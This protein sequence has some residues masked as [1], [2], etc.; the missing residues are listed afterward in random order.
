MAALESSPLGFDPRVLTDQS[1]WRVADALYTGLMKKAPRGEFLPDLAESC[2]SEDARVWSCRLRSG[3]LF[4][5]GRPMTSSDVA[6]TYE[7]VL[8]EG[9]RSSKKQALRVIERI[10]TPSPLMVV[11]HLRSPYSSFPNQLLLGIIP[12][13]TS[14][15]AARARP[16]G[17]GPFLFEF[18]RPDDRVSLRRFDGFYGEKARMARVVMRVIPDTTT[19]ALE[20]LRGSVHL[21]INSLSPDM[22]PRMEAASGVTVSR[23]PGSNHGYIAFNFKDPVLSKKEV[24]QALALALDR[25]ALASGLWRDTVEVTETLLPKDHWATD[26]DLP[27]LERDLERAGRLLDQAGFPERAEGRPRLT[28]TFKTS[29]DEMTVLQATAIAAQWREA[30]V[31][32]VI[33]SHDFSIFYEDVIHG[34]FR[35]FSMRWQGITDPDHYHDVFHTRSFPPGGW[36]RGFFS[37]PLVDS[38]IEKAR[39]TR[40]RQERQRLYFALQRRLLDELPYIPLYR[41]L[42]VAVHDSRLTGISSIPPTGDFTFLREIGRE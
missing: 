9:F 31:E 1:S 41:A 36:N 25:R 8:S 39:Q 35:L 26:P 22:L 23:L 10:E 11:F 33:R 19:R 37:D 17:T 7:S 15:E 14:L 34:N 27:P 28:L 16:I 13:G 24:R 12:A 5:D 6:F 20:L 4:H 21:A 2:D 38:W 3:V 32:T 42:T 18:Y 29:T 30:G 40:S